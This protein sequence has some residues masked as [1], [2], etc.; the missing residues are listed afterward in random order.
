MPARI[1]WSPGSLP[2]RMPRPQIG[3]RRWLRRRRRPTAPAGSCVVGRRGAPTPPSYTQ[4]PATCIVGE[5]PPPSSCSWGA[6]ALRPW[7][8]P[9]GWPRQTRGLWWR[10]FLGPPAPPRGGSVGP[11]GAASPPPPSLPSRGATLR[12]LGRLVFLAAALRDGGWRA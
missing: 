3:R 6:A 10:C 9:L 11:L 7:R 12:L 8:A 2:R 1:L 5:G 4:A